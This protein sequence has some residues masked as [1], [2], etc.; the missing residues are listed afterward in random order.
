MK[1]SNEV[2][3]NG[4]NGHTH[5]WK[6]SLGEIHDTQDT[7]HKTQDKSGACYTVTYLQPRVVS[8]MIAILP[9]I[10]REIEPS[11]EYL[12]KYVELAPL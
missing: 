10:H 12:K 1:H 9:E 3:G 11:L 7:R 6:H 2:G 4:T 8:V 5:T